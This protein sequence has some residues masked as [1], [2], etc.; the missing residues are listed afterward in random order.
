MCLLSGTSWIFKHISGQFS[1]LKC[2]KYIKELNLLNN[3]AI[4]VHGKKVQYNI[5]YKKIRKD[6]VFRINRQLQ[7]GTKEL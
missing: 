5:S 2:E 4:K 6:L 1:S 3:A 7:E